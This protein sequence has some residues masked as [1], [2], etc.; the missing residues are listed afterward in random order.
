MTNKLQKTHTMETQEENTKPL[1]PENF[2][3][4][5]HL[6]TIQEDEFVRVQ[7]RTA[8][9]KTASYYLE[10]TLQLNLSQA[11]IVVQQIAAGIMKL[12]GSDI[13]VFN[14][15]L[16]VAMERHIERQHP[17]NLVDVLSTYIQTK[18]VDSYIWPAN[19]FCTKEEAAKRKQLSQLAKKNS[20]ETSR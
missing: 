5:G 16:S 19:F 10:I 17:T 14:A 4:G 7:E 18:T 13:M 20:S 8:R 11:E 9:H 15:L 1:L 2:R 12:K 6:R 3:G